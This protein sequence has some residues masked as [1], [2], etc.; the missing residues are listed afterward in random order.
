MTTV[1]EI[2]IAPADLSAPLLQILWPLFGFLALVSVFWF[3]DALVRRHEG[4]GARGS[5][6]KGIGFAAVAL[7]A[8]IPP[9]TIQLR[10]AADPVA[11]EQGTYWK[12][13]G[14]VRQVSSLVS[15]IFLIT[16]TRALVVL[17]DGTVL[18]TDA[19]ALRHVPGDRVAFEPCWPDGDD[20]ACGGLRGALIS[21]R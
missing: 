3:V 11:L 16:R 18:T 6:V 21:I 13:T 10:P 4:G 20:W 15:G 9:L 7:L 2:A 8:L 19:S 5:V 17:E 1:D 12:V 14:T